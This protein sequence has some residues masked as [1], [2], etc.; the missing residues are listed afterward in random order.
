M[1]AGKGGNGRKGRET[2]EEGG[3]ERSEGGLID[4]WII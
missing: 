3:M 1:K 4:A 2:E